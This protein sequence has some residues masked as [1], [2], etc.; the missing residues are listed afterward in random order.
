MCPDLFYVMQ[1]KL[2]I[3]FEPMISDDVE[4][5]EDVII[6]LGG[7]IDPIKLTEYC[8]GSDIEETEFS[9]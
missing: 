4:N 7:Y 6:S 8:K 1:G 3:T 2:K 5:R 9:T